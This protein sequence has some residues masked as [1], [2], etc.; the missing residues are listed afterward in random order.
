MRLAIS[1]THRSR[2]ELFRFVGP[3]EVFASLTLRVS[4]FCG[5]FV[6]GDDRKSKMHNFKTHASGCKNARFPSKPALSN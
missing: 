1:R 5:S 3:R 6:A 4:I 2:I